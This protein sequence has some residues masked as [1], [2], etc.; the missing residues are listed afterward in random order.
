MLRIRA[1]LNELIFLLIRADPLHPPNPR[2]N[3]SGIVV[4]ALA[5]SHGP[6]HDDVLVSAPSV[7]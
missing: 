7:G 6:P 5:I 3:S 1:D 2:S 4:K